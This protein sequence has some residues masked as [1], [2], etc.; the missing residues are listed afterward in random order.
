VPPATV[1]PAALTGFTGG[2][3][4]YVYLPRQQPAKPANPPQPGG[5]SITVT[6]GGIITITTPTETVTMVPL[7]DGGVFVVMNTP[8]SPPVMIYIAPPSANPPI[9][10]AGSN[11]SPGYFGATDVPLGVPEK[12]P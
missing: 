1:F 10:W 6:T 3:W 2:D 12:K 5:V 9:L 8:G 4:N 7:P 11:D